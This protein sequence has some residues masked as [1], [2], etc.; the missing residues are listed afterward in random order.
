[1]DKAPAA[2]AEDVA[3]AAELISEEVPGVE[4]AATELAALEVSAVAA[5]DWSLWPAADVTAVLVSTTV[6]LGRLVVFISETT[7]TNP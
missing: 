6:E 1:M 3:A 4:A 2:V 5:V 7:V